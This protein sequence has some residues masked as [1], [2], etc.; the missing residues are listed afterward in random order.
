MNRIYVL[1]SKPLQ[2]LN[3]FNIPEVDENA[4]FLMTNSFF[5]AKEL[6][7]NLSNI[8][9]NCILFE[10]PNE[11]YKWLSQNSKNGDVLYINSDYGVIQ[12][13]WLFPLRNRKIFVYEEGI[14]T[15]RMDLNQ[16]SSFIKTLIKSLGFK[17][18]FGGGIFTSGIYVY[19]KYR[20]LKSKKS[21][22]KLVLAFDK[23]FH[24][25]LKTFRYKSFI[26]QMDSAFYEKINSKKILVYLTSW[27]INKQAL[28]IIN[29]YDSYYKI[30][31]FH[32]HVNKTENKLVSNFDFVV[33]GNI[34]VEYLILELLNISNNIIII[35]EN[36]SA[37]MH[38]NG[39]S[40]I[41]NIILD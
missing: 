6:Y 9:I 5:G 4:T 28:D 16:N 40:N 25:H 21:Y 11:P 36:S 41:K 23:E 12:T 35:H 15:Y 18:Y 30:I 17:S 14:G 7:T 38:F 8:N 39:V 32:P 31:K 29:Q 37:M 10:K 24:D 19:D 3:A 27:K 20:Y 33:E 1:F 26:Y 13:L 34:M 22:N 2:F